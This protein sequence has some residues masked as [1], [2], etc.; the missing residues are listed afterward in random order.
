MSG[1]RVSAA[2]SSAVRVGGSDLGAREDVGDNVQRQRPTEDVGESFAARV[3]RINWFV[4]DAKT[5]SHEGVFVDVQKH[6]RA[7]TCE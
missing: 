5:C 3:L 7:L 2:G 4:D 1:L 6:K